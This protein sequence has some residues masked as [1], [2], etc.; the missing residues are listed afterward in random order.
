[1]ARTRVKQ[2]ARADTERK[3]GPLSYVARRLDG[4]KLQFMELARLSGAEIV[5]AVVAEWD[6]Y[7]TTKRECTSLDQLCD[8]VGV[9]AS[10]FLAQVVKSAFLVNTDLSNVL[11]ATAQPRIVAKAIKTALLQKGF[12]DREMLLQATGLVPKGG[13]IHVS[14]NAQAIAGAKAAA[15]AIGSGLPSFEAEMQRTAEAVRTG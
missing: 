8:R 4:G 6:T 11:L 5:K 7:S 15:G 14:A 1:M 10:D 9:P 2:L 12:K 3:T 13:G